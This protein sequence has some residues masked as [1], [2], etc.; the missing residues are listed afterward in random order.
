ME[1]SPEDY[2]DQIENWKERVCEIVFGEI[3]TEGDPPSPP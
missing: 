3:D 2:L 1:T